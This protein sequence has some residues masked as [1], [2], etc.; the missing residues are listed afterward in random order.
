MKGRLIAL[1]AVVVGLGLML[2][3]VTPNHAAEAS[4][5]PEEF[6]L[7]TESDIAFVND[8][9]GLGALDLRRVH[10]TL[11]GTAM[12][13]AHNAQQQM[14]AGNNP[15]QMATLRDA[16]LAVVEQIS[17]KKYPEA[18]KLAAELKLDI[19]PNA[20]ASTEPVTLKG[21]HRFEL[22]ELMQPFRLDKTSTGRLIGGRGLEAAVREYLNKEK[23]GDGKHAREVALRIVPMADL[24]QEFAPARKEGAKDPA[25]WKKWTKEMQDYAREASDAIKDGK[26]D[27]AAKAFEN[28]DASCTRCH[29]VFRD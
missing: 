25:N 14:I 28:L 16:A 1:P 13:I 17:A 26:T 11:F 6:A 10:G 9:L 7:V 27:V 2:G 19:E 12:M 21:M 29:N 5:S 4:L 18:K 20:N 22:Y 23:I 15:Q 24:T 3:N 8:S